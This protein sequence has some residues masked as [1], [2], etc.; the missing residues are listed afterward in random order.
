[1][2]DQNQGNGEP[3]A[4]DRVGQMLGDMAGVGQRMANRNLRLWNDVASHLRAGEY[5]VNNMTTDIAQSWMAAMD[6]LDDVWSLWTRVPDRER[7]A[8]DLPTAFLLFRPSGRK[9]T[10][11]PEGRGKDGKEVAGYGVADPVWIRVPPGLNEP[12]PH[13]RIDL[14]GT[15]PD[16]ATAL[17]NSLTTA[18][19]K[20]RHAYQLVTSYP[21]DG[22]ELVPGTYSGVVY[23][24]QPD[25]R[26]L[27]NLRVVVEAP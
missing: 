24:T 19:G 2:A 15:D 11:Y 1:M 27:A 13:A 25:V 9:R 4:W 20:G 22:V 18:L 6:N 12:P 21:P 7:V 5:T 23:V 26:P 8:T 14:S 17:S 3:T 16:G 10:I